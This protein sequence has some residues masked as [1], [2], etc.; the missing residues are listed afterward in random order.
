S[1]NAGVNSKKS[2]QTGDLIDRKM[3]R[4][5]RAKK[6]GLR[7]PRPMKCEG[8]LNLQRGTAAAAELGGDRHVHQLRAL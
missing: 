7:I 1:H 4:I 6:M 2:A 5:K 3:K 8:Q